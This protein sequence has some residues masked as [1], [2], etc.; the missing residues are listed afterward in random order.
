MI[1]NIKKYDIEVSKPRAKCSKKLNQQEIHCIIDYIYINWITY[2]LTLTKLIQTLN[3]DIHKNIFHMILK[4]I[5]YNRRIVYHY[6][7]F[8]KYDKLWRLEFAR[9]HLH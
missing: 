2:H 3:L 7:F 1:E 8:N 4:V 5:D 9:K 6:S